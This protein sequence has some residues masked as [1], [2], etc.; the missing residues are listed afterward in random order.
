[1]KGAE[2]P[3]AVAAVPAVPHLDDG[4]ADERVEV[5]HQL[6]V[7]VGHIEGPPDDGDEADGAVADP[8]VGVAQE[9]S[10]GGQRY[11]WVGAPGRVGA[12]VFSG[13]R[14]LPMSLTNS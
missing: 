8:Q 7:D 1:M 2:L 14:L 11:R 4:L 5:G 6:A 3:E 12:L 10:C 13:A 9:G